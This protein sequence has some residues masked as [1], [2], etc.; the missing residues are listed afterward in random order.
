MSECKQQA[1]KA[2]L[3]QQ[4]REHEIRAIIDEI[5]RLTERSQTVPPSD[6]PAYQEALPIATE[7]SNTARITR[8]KAC[9]A[10]NQ[11]EAEL[12]RAAWHF[13][14]GQCSLKNRTLM[15]SWDAHT[16]IIPKRWGQARYEARKTEKLER[17]MQEREKAE[18]E[19]E[20]QANPEPQHKPGPKLKPKPRP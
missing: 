14:D 11:A 8:Q 18:A 13:K 17:K 6:R 3:E 1:G 15:D 4:E 5:A 19:A 20:A 9:L 12:K 7:T 16:G 10:F 2:A